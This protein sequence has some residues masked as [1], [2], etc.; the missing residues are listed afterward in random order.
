MFGGGRMYFLPNNTKDPQTNITGNR[1]DNRN[2][3][4]EW[5]ENMSKQN[6][7]FKYL[8]NASEFRKTDFKSYDHV[9]GLFAYNHMS[10]DNKRNPLVEPS[11]SEVFN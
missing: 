11:I 2:L 9:L 10:F 4:N 5:H 8:W 7:T 3:I 6:K 1:V